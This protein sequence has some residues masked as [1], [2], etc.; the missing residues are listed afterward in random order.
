MAT[1]NHKGDENEL[2]ESQGGRIVKTGTILCPY[3]SFN[4]YISALHPDCNAFF[5]RPKRILTPEA[6]VWYDNSPI[7]RNTLGDKMKQLS[8]EAGLSRI[9]TNHCLRATSITILNDC[10]EARH[11]M[12][13][14]GHKSE[15]SLRH[16]AKTS[17]QKRQEMALTIAEAT[18]GS[19]VQKLVQSSSQSKSP[20]SSS[21]S[22]ETVL[23]AELS[24]F[25]YFELTSSQESYL[26][27]EIQNIP[28]PTTSDNV[29][30]PNTNMQESKSMSEVFPMSQQR[31]VFRNEHFQT[32]QTSRKFVSPTYNFHN[33][34]VH[35]HNH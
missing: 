23:P 21:E 35:I 19:T 34:V 22:K 25:D 31:Q 8:T 12:T 7:G 27:K 33:S 10:Y 6:T 29:I 32:M 15:S 4:K 28:L 2:N 13:V 11:V 18:T 20:S 24:N 17:E 1:K 3:L 16:Y 26:F 14:S 5:Q 9:Y 30:T